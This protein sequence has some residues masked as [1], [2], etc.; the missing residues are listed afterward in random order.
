MRRFTILQH[1]KAT[2]SAI[3]YFKFSEYKWINFLAKIRD[4][5]LSRQQ[6]L[7]QGF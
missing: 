6:Q 3:K 4:S 7:S 2:L 5:S 1:V